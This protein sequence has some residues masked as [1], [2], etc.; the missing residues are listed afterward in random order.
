[1]LI[2]RESECARIDEA[3]ERARLGRRAALLIRGEAGIGKTSLLEYAVERA[4]DSTVVR[5]TGIES[6]SEIEFSGLLEVT[7]PL[8]GLLDELPERQTAAL[9]GVLGLD[10]TAVQDPFT[11]GAGTLSLLSVAAENRPLLLVVDDAQWLDRASADAVR[12]AARRLDADRVCLLIAVRSDE[13]RSDEWAGFDELRLGG[14]SLADAR[15]LVPGAT[16]LT[17]ADD[18]L[19]RIHESTQGN[20]L[21]LLEL[22]QLLDTEQ[23]TGAAPIAEPLPASESVRAAFARRADRLPAGARQA[24]GV[25]AVASSP[26]LAPIASALDRLGVGAAALEPAEDAGLV[27]IAAGEVRFRHPL[28][29]AAIHETSPASERR[30]AHRALAAAYEELGDPDRSARHLAAGTLGPDEAAAGAVAAAA[31]RSRERSAHQAA[32]EAFE[33]AARLTPA[34]PA[35]WAYLTDAAEAAWEAGAHARAEELAAAAQAATD[36]LRLRGR[37]LLLR[38]RLELQA[39][40]LARAR[41]AF[42]EAGRAFEGVD[43]TKT[44]I[45]TDLGI[46]MCHFD[47]ESDRALELAG[48]LKEHVRGEPDLEPYVEYVLGRSLVRA[49]RMA[50]GSPLLEHAVASLLASPEATRVQLVRA[51]TML[52][53]LERFRESLEIIERVTTQAREDGPTALAYALAQSSHF[54]GL[55]GDWQRAAADAEEG[56]ALAQALELKNLEAD[57]IAN[58]VRL[59]ARRGDEVRSR[60]HVA[61]VGPVLSAAGMV[62]TTLQIE[63]SL[64]LLELALDRLDDAV[65][66]LGSAAE[67][68]ARRGFAERDLTPEPDLVEALVRAGRDAE[69]AEALERWA[70]APRAALPW[71]PQLVERCRGLLASEDD[72]DGHMLEAL[73]LHADTDEP[74][75]RARTLLCYG[76]RLRRSGRRREARE[77]I[78]EAERLFDT[79]G[80]RPWSDRA[81]RELRASGERLR[82]REVAESEELTPQELQIALQVAEGKTNKE[83]GAAL[84]LSHKTVEFHLSRIYR[85]LDLSSRAELIR[86][87]A[88]RDATAELVGGR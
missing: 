3:L 46:W 82:R 53:L 22:P 44:V 79:L 52:G 25:V 75:A 62:S 55:S 63:C 35:R 59:E 60:E 42:L 36:E 40:T 57:C 72:V 1:V 85:K 6:E 10:R 58:L 80:A 29:R 43:L 16:R 31:E 24:L 14:L 47:G 27:S 17:V 83:V 73:R 88:G 21:A 7:R 12:F 49:G 4:A 26:E 15:E 77:R 70:A 38:G 56:A 11:V 23:L 5:A 32:S 86:R 69:A 54:R 28:V 18:V 66:R 64:G 81:R 9:R 65:V 84:F 8:L 34:G 68:I 2:G 74:F 33:L 71:A 39:G 61:A 48:A 13:L 41:D 20:P 50:E 51:A 19:A 45:A 87:F 76:E 67:E 78:R 37:L 30:A